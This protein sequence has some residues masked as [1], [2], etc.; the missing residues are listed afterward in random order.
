M[1]HVGDGIL[2]LHVVALAPERNEL[3]QG[4]AA[5]AALLAPFRNRPRD[6]AAVVVDHRLLV[7]EG[8]RLLVVTQVE[9]AAGRVRRLRVFRIH[10]LENDVGIG[11]AVAHQRRLADTHQV[12]ALLRFVFG[13]LVEFLV[14]VGALQVFLLVDKAFRG[15]FAGRLPFAHGQLLDLGSL[16]MLAGLVPVFLVEVESRKAEVGLRAHEGSPCRIGKHRFQSRDGLVRMFGFLVQ[17]RKQVQALEVVGMVLARNDGFQGEAADVVFLVPVKAVGALVLHR[18]HR[19]MV[20]KIA[21]EL[22]V[23][24]NGLAPFT[25]VAERFADEEHGLGSTLLVLGEALEHA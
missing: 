7:V 12:V 14:F 5:F 22:I 6:E 10:L 19:I 1:V 21:F 18:A 17:E 13:V 23:L 2:R 15:L 16:V 25:L 9:V 3:A 11:I 4:V 8:L 20:G 24:D